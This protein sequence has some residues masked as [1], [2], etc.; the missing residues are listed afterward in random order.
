MLPPPSLVA[1]FDG[2]HGEDDGHDEEEDA[3]DEA[4]SDCPTFDVLRQVVLELLADGV[5]RGRVGEHSEPVCL[6]SAHVFH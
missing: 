4:G 6:S 1:D 5:G 2:A 3:T